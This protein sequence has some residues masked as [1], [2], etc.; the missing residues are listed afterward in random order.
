[1]ARQ[2][3]GGHHPDLVR[4]RQKRKSKRDPTRQRRHHPVCLGGS[5]YEYKCGL[6]WVRLK[7][8]SFLK[9]SFFDRKHIA[10]TIEQIEKFLTADTREDQEPAKIFF[11]TRNTVEGV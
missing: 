3:F 10:M 6:L 9:W 1:M 2:Q 5:R 7:P 4:S 8:R 11:K